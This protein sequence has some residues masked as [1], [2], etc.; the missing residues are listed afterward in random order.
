MINEKQPVEFQERIRDNYPLLQVTVEQQQQISLAIG[1]K[2]TPP[3]PRIWQS[4]AAKNH[5]FSSMDEKWH[6][7]LTS[8][9]LALS[10][11][12]Y[13]R[14]ENFIQQLE[15]PLSALSEIYRPHFFERIGLRYV[16]LFKRSTLDL[17]GTDWTE[18][19]EPFVLGFMSNAE[20]KKDVRNQS[21]FVELNIGNGAIAQINIGKG[22]VGDIFNPSTAS[23]EESF[24]VDSDMYMTHKKID[25][26]HDSLNYLHDHSTRLIRAIITPKLHEAM[27]PSPL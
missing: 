20:I 7:N 10:T 19:I 24:I 9:F 5:Q 3:P 15:E 21:S 23:N 22:F 16:D 14:W 13:D 11:S 8:T 26:L 12:N 1:A 6:I 2:E 27:E 17:H 4:E 25:E 18:L